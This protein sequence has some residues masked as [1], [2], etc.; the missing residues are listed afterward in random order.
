MVDGKIL[1]LDPSGAPST[2][3]AEAKKLAA[4]A[5][6]DKVMISFDG[7]SCPFFRLYAAKEFAEAAI[8]AKVPVL[9]VYIREAEPCDTVR[10]P[11]APAACAHRPRPFT[12]ADERVA[13]ARSLTPAAC[14]ARRRCS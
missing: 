11:H 12:P 5:G 10:P 4:E 8:A 9:H 13:C 1:S 7:V 2:L 6:S 3:L 14:T